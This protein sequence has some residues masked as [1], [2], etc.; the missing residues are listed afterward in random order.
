VKKENLEEKY[1]NINYEDFFDWNEKGFYKTLSKKVKE[2]F[3][4]RSHKATTLYWGKIIV[5]VLLAILFLQK[6][7]EGSL[8]F[9][10]LYGT[11]LQ[12]IGFAI[13]HDA[14]HGAVSK[15]AWVNTISSVIWNSW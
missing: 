1:Q 11:I 5:M 9:S 3:K 4:E 12:A 14:S 10:F 13:M 8:F 15:K 2:R 6:F 7:W